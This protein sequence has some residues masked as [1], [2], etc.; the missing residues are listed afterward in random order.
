MNIPPFSIFSAVSELAVTAV[1]LY[2]VLD[3]LRGR[4]LR[5]KPL[6]GV[7][8]FE[9][10]VNIVYMASRASQV[11]RDAEM[12][13]WMRAFFAGHGILSLLMFLIL[14]TVFILATTDEHL[15]RPTW[16]RRH[17][18]LTWLLLLFWMVSVLSGEALFVIHY[19]V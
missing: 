16:F 5:W 10:C 11:D 17:V 6:G 19:L 12:S 15:K 13:V 4:P 3:N 18:R 7:L 2:T 1:V 14:V 9:L 8:A